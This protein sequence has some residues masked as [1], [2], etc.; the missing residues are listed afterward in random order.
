MFK[1]KFFPWFLFLTTFYIALFSFL[2]IFRLYSFGS[3]YY[4]LGIMHQVVFNTF[5]GDFLEFTNPHKIVS[6]SQFYKLNLRDLEQLN[7]LR[8]A[9]HFDPILALLSLFYF[10]WEGPETLLVLQSLIIGLGALFVYKIARLVL[11]SKFLSFLFGVLYLFYYPLH[12]INL[13]D[14]HAVS[15]SPTLLLAGVY[16]LLKENFRLNY[17]ALIFLFLATLTKENV[18]LVIFLI[19]IWVYL[20]SKNHV[21]LILSFLSFV[22]FIAVVKFLMP[23]FA[24]GSF[25]GGKYYSFSLQENLQRF[26]SKA[27]F[28]YLKNLTSPLLFL[29]FFSPFNLLPALS[30]ILKNTLSSNTNM[31]SLYFHYSSALL[32]FLFISSIFAV[33][34]I[35]SVNFRKILLIFLVFYNFGLAF[36]K[37]PASYFF[38]KY[39]LD[40][41]RLKLVKELSKRYSDYNLVLSSTGQL[42]PFFSGRRYFIHFLYDPAFKQVGYSKDDIIKSANKYRLAKVII[43]AKWEIQGELAE[44]Y[45]EKLKNDKDYKIVFEKAGVE[46]YEKIGKN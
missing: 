10:V 43:V 21:Y 18:I 8:F 4:D 46:V 7:T 37:G 42:A 12:F 24:G 17:K 34:K 25:F 16:F 27:T 31:R 40:G 15:L 33:S 30:E 36:K 2:S 44:Y 11:K 39:K 26:F 28:E 22:Y 14:F 41:Q 1:D 9:I 6:I 35:K 23:Y 13:F 19:F 45:Y 3:H 32:S 20:K 29:P 5:K 38:D